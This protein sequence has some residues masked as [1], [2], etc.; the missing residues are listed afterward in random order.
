MSDLTV[1]FLMSV[2]LAAQQTPPPSVTFEQLMASVPAA[3]AASTST[4]PAGAQEIMVTWHTSAATSS[5]PQPSPPVPPP[6]NQFE[7]TGRRTLTGP[8][9]LERHPELS[10]DQ[11]AVV[12]ADSNGSVVFWSLIK[13]PRIVRAEQP[14][15]GGVLTGRVLY[16]G[17]VDFL[18]ALPDSPQIVQV[19]LYQ[20][21]WTGA[22]WILDLLG[23]FSVA[24]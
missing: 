15:A 23:A 13:D 11:L 24:R 1:L 18:V 16:R 8:L 6:E 3:P 5:A 4:Q 7:V 20:P 17:P 19:G 10:S 9:P 12:G 14:G 2:L 22:Q 21:R